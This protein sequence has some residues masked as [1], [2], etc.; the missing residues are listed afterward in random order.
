MRL[1]PAL[2]RS[3]GRGVPGHLS[4]WAASDRR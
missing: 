4:R 3:Q 2:G 1:T